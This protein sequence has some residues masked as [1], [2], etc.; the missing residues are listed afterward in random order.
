SY[1][2]A[3]YCEGTHHVNVRDGEWNLVVWEIPYVYRDKVTEIIIKHNIHGSQPDM[4]DTSVLYFSDLRAQVVDEDYYEGWALGAERVAYCHSGY[5]PGDEKIA[6]TGAGAAAG[7][8]AS[9]AGAGVAT[10]DAA[11]ASSAVAG[12]AAGDAAAVGA[13]AAAGM[14]GAN[15]FNI[16]DV[17]SG[18][19]AYKGEIQFVEHEGEKFGVMDFSKLR[20]E[21]QYVIGIGDKATKPFYIAGN[22]Y[23]PAIWKTIN[24][25]Y[26]ERCGA[27]IPE[28]HLPCH[29]DCFS[30]HPLDGRKISV[31]GG[32]HDAGDLSQ[33]LCNTSESV[34]AFIDMATRLITNPA[35]APAGAGAA[36]TLHSRLLDEARWG[37]NWMMRTRFGD[38]FR[39][40]WTTIGIWTKNIVGDT[41]DLTGQAYNDPFE[42]FCASAAEAAGAGAFG[43][44]DTDFSRYCLKCAVEDFDFAW[45]VLKNP[46]KG[47]TRRAT[48]EVQVYGQ[49]AFAAAMLYKMTGDAAYLDKAAEMADIVMACQ[50]TE[51]PDWAGTS[52][53]EQNPDSLGHTGIRLKGFFYQ[54][55]EHKQPMA[56]DH[57]S[58]EQAPIMAL[59]RLCEYAPGH[60]SS[61]A[62]RR[63]V[64]LYGGYIKAIAGLIPPY[65]LLPSAIYLHGDGGFENVWASFT[66][67]ENE[68]LKD[69]Y[70]AQVKNGIKLA[71]DYYLRRFPVAFSFRGFHGVLLTK[72]KAAAVAA[73]LLGDDELKAIATRQ[74]EWVMGKNPFTQSSMFGE[75]YDFAP[76]YTEFAYDIVG[77]LPVGF[78]T[79]E[80]NDKPFY[81]MMNSATYKEIWVH[82]SSR[83]LWTL[84]EL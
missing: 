63:S 38:G 9:V 53:V 36:A 52:P 48:H 4:S 43:V 23:I 46:D 79:F 35:A 37:L 61:G 32:W 8:A 40:T 83:F 7:D 3:K 2:R 82:S 41:D 62:W 34:H 49:G 76:Q 29:L 10:G 17:R 33:G 55:R 66:S 72:A 65:G 59:A 20:R 56:Y 74:L 42:N 70:N 50:Q 1:P 16:I 39:V 67:R 28:V 31:A 78:Q 27:D 30:V 47:F 69:D 60:K 44:T 73:N 84:A 45:D 18:E 14:P 13:G 6:L 24:F 19:A 26:Q 12:A 51:Y 54:N 77:A 64:E 21:G 81:P 75:G 58:H 68:V 57:R 25:F 80:N 22:P 15:K 11:A 5:R 71:D